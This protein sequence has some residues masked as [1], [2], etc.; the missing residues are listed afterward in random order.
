MMEESA[1]IRDRIRQQIDKWTDDI[2]DLTRSNRLLNFRPHK[3]LTAEILEPSWDAVVDGLKDGRHWDFY[4]PGDANYVNDVLDTGEEL[5]QND[6][7]DLDTKDVSSKESLEDLDTLLETPRSQ[8]ELV[9]N[10]VDRSSINRTLRSLERRSSQEFM[11]KGLW[12]LYLAVGFLTWNWPGDDSEVNSP[13]ILIPVTFQRES[14]SAPFRLF[15]TE[16]DLAVN[17]VLA[18][19]LKKDFSIEMPAFDPNGEDDFSEFFKDMAELG[20]DRNWKVETRVVL[21]P[22]TFAKE[23]MY[24][25]LVDNMEKIMGHDLIVA[26]SDEV[27]PGRDRYGFDPLPP[28][29]IDHK[30]PPEQLVNI[31][32]AD[33]SQLQCIVAA[34]EGRSFVMDG[35]PG[36]G[37][38][39]TVANIIAELLFLGKTV[40]FVSDKAAALDVVYKRLKKVG[41]ND[42]ILELHS[43]KTTRRE[44][45]K[46]LGTGIDQI[47]KP[48]PAMDDAEIKKLLLRRRELSAYA[49][50]INETRNPLGRSAHSV[51]GR[52]SYLDGEHVPIAPLMSA[53]DQH[54]DADRFV[55]ICDS[56]QNLSRNWDPVERGEDFLWRDL[57]ETDRLVR[58]QAEISD[59]L[60]KMRQSNEK[61]EK[62]WESASDASGIWFSRSTLGVKKLSALLEHIG[63]KP[64]QI[65]PVWLST[66]DLHSVVSLVERLKDFSQRYLETEKFLL[67]MSS[68]WQSLT[69]DENE[70]VKKAFR[71]LT[72]LNTGLVPSKENLSL[73]YLSRLLILFGSNFEKMFQWSDTAL[74][75][76]G[77]LGLPDREPSISRAIKIGQLY[78]LS[79]APHRPEARWMEKSTFEEVREIERHIKRLV[80][81]YWELKAQVDPVFTEDVLN[82]DLSSLILRFSQMHRGLGKLKGDYRSDK[83]AIESVAR[84]GKATK[85]VIDLLPNVLKLKDTISHIERIEKEN[86]KLLGRPYYIGVDT[87]FEVFEQA[88]KLVETAFS[89]AGSHFDSSKL[90]QIIGRDAEVN[91]QIYQLA[92][93]LVQDLLELKESILTFPVDTKAMITSDPLVE[94][95]PRWQS[96]LGPLKI[97]ADTL[98]KLDGLTGS[99]VTYS[100]CQS[101]F[102]K[103]LKITD[104]SDSISGMQNDATQFFGEYYVGLLTDFRSLESSLSWAMFCREIVGGPL[105]E[106]TI[107]ALLNCTL[108]PDELNN[109]F[110]QWVKDV[111]S[112]CTHFL[113]D[114]AEEIREQLFDSFEEVRDQLNQFRVTLPDIFRWKN[115]ND[116]LGELNIEG[117][118]PVL[119]YAIENRVTAEQLPMVVERSVLGSWLEDVLE[120][121]KRLQHQQSSDRD[122]FVKDF[123]KLDRQIVEASSGKVMRACNDRRPRTNTGV[124][125]II[126]R[127]AEK[128]RRHM[129]VRDL[130]SKTAPVTQAIKPCFMMTPLSVSQFLPSDLSFDLVIFDEAS[131]VRPGDA[132]NCIY[133]GKQLVIAGDQKQLPPT[134]FFAESMADDSDLY[135]EGQLEEYESILDLCK[136]S[137][138][139]PSLSLRW[140]RRSQ[141]ED[142]IAFS[143]YSFYDGN[144]ITFPSSKSVGEDVGI[145]MYRVN[146]MYRRAGARDNLIEAEK[147]VERVLHHARCNANLTLGVVAFSDA[148]ADAIDAKLEL[149][150]RNSPDLDEYFSSDRLNGVFVKNLENVQGDERDIIIFSVGYGRDEFGKLTM[151]FG[152]IN[153]PGGQRRLNVAITRARRR[154]EIVSSIGPE[155]FSDTGSEGVRHFRRYLDF[156]ERGIEALALDLELS[157]GDVESPFEEE[158]LRVLHSHGYDVVPQVGTA[159]YRIDI[160]VCKPGR[161]GQFVLGVEC[162]G[163]MYHSSMVARDRDRLR[164]EVLEGLGWRL[165]RIWGTS[166]YRNRDHEIGRL[167]SAVESAIQNGPLGL[168]VPKVRVTSRSV[169]YE[170]WDATAPPSWAR[171]YEIVNLEMNQYRIGMEQ[172]S[173]RPEMKRLIAETVKIE[174]PVHQD[175][176]LRRLC[177]AWGVR[178]AGSNIKENFS[179]A[180]REIGRDWVTV[181]GEFLYPSNMTDCPVRIPLNG[182]DESRRGALFVAPEELEQAIV[183]MIQD[184]RLSE[185]GQLISETARLF[186]WQ[187]KSPDVVKVLT[188][189]LDRVL[190][191]GEATEIDGLLRFSREMEA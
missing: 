1:P 4:L 9:T 139:L 39:Q 147:V 175:T 190:K 136:G 109:A 133:R 36:T 134:S 101:F 102:E 105:D 75:L 45:A 146:G 182:V 76:A 103:R 69:P 173:S 70:P 55:K 74:R 165:Y 24:R 169:E 179:L 143:N 99:S 34:R 61:L 178:R 66:T 83:K 52:I 41:L 81:E 158:V 72:D 43:H 186:G 98:R 159:G 35:P 85:E 104:L 42:Y 106:A 51:I 2:I 115:F 65:I 167:L 123:Q 18:A 152:P 95:T 161:T 46:A 26:I 92:A 110:K 93:E 82:L 25:D 30:A 144:L 131:Q 129:P 47:P 118:E 31:L 64:T 100:A 174:G 141:H 15:Q 19:K 33:S 189:A 184:L 162:D 54:L 166:W 73:D 13:L 148:Q 122:E 59:E 156:A 111:D 71:E 188:S 22:F 113:Q 177:K 8:N 116:T 48:S 120:D 187:R 163:A 151:N 40:L 168:P 56:A 88:I 11:D 57:A 112:F 14:P 37:K 140:H 29:E 170:E 157:Q 183:S 126:R 121:D 38:S 67:G 5:V 44:V 180:I 125:N 10:K 119:S 32:D 91:S 68:E 191:R 21:S 62:Y 132:I 130:I 181:K 79:R 138:A 171:P 63:T 135:E 28:E 150:R 16:D 80:S 97:I 87:D 124:A 20:R 127:E 86:S 107:S 23:V 60:D 160:G 12:V 164:Q 78:M 172:A 53:I 145:E 128:K 6:I 90:A 94:L 149:A 137:G 153:K 176:V 7:I 49:D 142:L 89:L 77:L 154:V 84:I 58:R 27:S 17:P 3:L 117:L 96:A 114:R 50:A 108:S 185:R 155:D